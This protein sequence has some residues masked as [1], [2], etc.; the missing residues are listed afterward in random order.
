MTDA[1]FF[2]LGQFFSLRALITTVIGVGLI[3]VT[4]FVLPWLEILNIPAIQQ[5]LSPATIVFTLAI[6]MV[7]SAVA[8]NIVS[9]IFLAVAAILSF[10][11]PYVTSTLYAN[12]LF[13]SGY[14]AIIVIYL[15]TALLAGFFATMEMTGRTALLLIGIIYGLQGLIGA[16]T[17]LY[18][19]L[20]FAQAIEPY[21]LQ[22]LGIAF[23][24]TI[25]GFPVYDT[26]VGIFSIIYMMVFIIISRKRVSTTVTSNK[27]EIIGQIL[28][29]LSIVAGIV[30]MIFAGFKYTQAEAVLI[31]GQTNTDFMNIIFS[32]LPSGDFTFV[33]YLNVF[34]ILPIVGFAMGI[35]MGIMVYKR[36][37]GT[38]D[39]MR[40]NFEGSFLWLN[41]APLIA[42]LLLSN[43]V[44]LGL[45]ADAEFYLN[46]PT[47]IA[48]FTEYT[49]LLLIN[50]FVAYI[51][52]RI[53]AFFKS[54]SKK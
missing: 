54:V 43:V 37:Q 36:A 15:L 48:I 5:W 25:N 41:L 13:S 2:H 23:G 47:V 45:N 10:Y 3:S 17:S 11:N 14:W 44:I 12:N 33:K 49:F 19:S 51:I 9:S 39:K 40:F 32:K 20:N 21:Q 1:K 53:I 8:K 38:T 4:E 35:A 46:M 22:N 18:L 24:E 31:Y 50:L 52:F 7:G 16:G 42:S 26:V 27:H 34:Y 30:F 29:F 28:I 6:I